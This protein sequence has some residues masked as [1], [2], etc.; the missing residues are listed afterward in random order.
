M[1]K[2]CN[3]YRRN[4]CVA[5]YLIAEEPT[6]S[7]PQPKRRRMGVVPEKR[8]ATNVE[9]VE[10]TQDLGENEFRSGGGFTN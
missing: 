5:L 8:E 4:L 7:P 10:M 1:E 3:I 9:E 6:T 2:L